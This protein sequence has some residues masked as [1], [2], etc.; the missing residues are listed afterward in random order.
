MNRWIAAVLG[1][2][3]FLS[4]SVANTLPDNLAYMCA[5][6]TDACSAKRPNCPSAVDTLKRFG[7]D[8]PGAAVQGAITPVQPDAQ[9]AVVKVLPRLNTRVRQP[10][11]EEYLPKGVLKKRESASTDVKVCVSPEGQLS[12]APVVVASSGMDKIDRA[13]IDFAKVLKYLPGSEDGV[14]A[15]SCFSFRTT[16]RR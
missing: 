9:R 15:A 8:C 1:S 16:F 14:P 12:G 5:L 7:F 10:D 13:S 6:A 3:A 11:M 2:A 4:Q